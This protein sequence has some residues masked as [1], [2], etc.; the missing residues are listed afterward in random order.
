M[1]MFRFTGEN[2]VYNY[3]MYGCAIQQ[4]VADWRLSWSVNSPTMDPQFPFGEVQVKLSLVFI[5]TPL[6]LVN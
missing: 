6:V 2:N 5:N 3:E 4:M 1:F